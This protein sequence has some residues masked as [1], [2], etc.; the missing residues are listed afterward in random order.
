MSADG[1]PLYQLDQE[2]IRQLNPDIIITQTQCDV[3]APG[4]KDVQEALNDLLGDNVKLIS[5]HPNTLED[6][7]KSIRTLAEALDAPEQ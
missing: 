2:L 7:Y 1:L 4:E 6:I 3:C 5:L